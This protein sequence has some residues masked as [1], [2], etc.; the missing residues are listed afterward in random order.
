MKVS[1]WVSESQALVRKR[2]ERRRNG[3]WTGI[4]ALM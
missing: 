3:R 2:E 4:P 1:S